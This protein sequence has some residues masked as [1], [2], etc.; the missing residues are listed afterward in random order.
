MSEPIPVGPQALTNAQA[1][2]VAEKIYTELAREFDGAAIFKIG[3][4]LLRIEAR[5]RHARKVREQVERA[6]APT[7]PL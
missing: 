1:K 4:N 7:L 3:N 2:A 5:E 6:H